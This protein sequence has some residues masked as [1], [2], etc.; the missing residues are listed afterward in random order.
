MQPPI[1]STP[2]LLLLLLLHLLLQN[3]LLLVFMCEEKYKEPSGTEEN[4]EEPSLKE[5]DATR[6]PDRPCGPHPS[7]S[8][9]SSSSL[10]SYLRRNIKNRGEPR[11]TEENRGEPFTHRGASYRISG[12][13]SSRRNPFS[14]SVTS[15]PPLDRWSGLVLSQSLSLSLSLSLFVT[16]EIPGESV[17]QSS[18][19][20][21]GAGMSR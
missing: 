16:M 19:R 10:F 9:S 11:E 3:L 15:S 21:A 1:R 4:R 18:R 13:G 2:I 14:R 8:S 7:S 17:K 6:S 12:P 5:K 20:G